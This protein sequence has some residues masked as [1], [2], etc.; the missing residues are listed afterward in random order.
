ML[1][2]SSCRRT[3]LH[4]CNPSG[5]E[6]AKDYLKAMTAVESNGNFAIAHVGV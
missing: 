1:L 2:V 4:I 3:H 6:F 5:I